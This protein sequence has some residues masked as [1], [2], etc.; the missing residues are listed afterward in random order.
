MSELLAARLRSELSAYS[1]E[2][3]L[4]SSR[5]AHATTSFVP[6]TE[7]FGYR[8]G[9]CAGNCGGVCGG[10][11][12]SRTGATYVSHVQSR[13][14]PTQAHSGLMPTSGGSYSYTAVRAIG[15]N[16]SCSSRMGP[17]PATPVIRAESRDA[18]LQAC[19]RAG[20]ENLAGD[21]TSSYAG[22][23]YNQLVGAAGS[24]GSCSS[25]MGPTPATPVIR[26]ES[27]AAPLQD[28]QRA[29]SENL[30][31]DNGPTP[32][33]PVIRAESRAAPFQASFAP[34]G[35]QAP[36]SLTARSLLRPLSS[37]F[38]SCSPGP[39]SRTLQDVFEYPQELQRER[40]LVATSEAR[41]HMAPAAQPQENL[42]LPIGS[43]SPQ[44]GPAVYAMSQTLE[45]SNAELPSPTRPSTSPSSFSS[46]AV[47]VS[48]ETPR[49]LPR[50]SDASP[51]GVKEVPAVVI[52]TVLTGRRLA[53][54]KGSKD[55]VLLHSDEDTVSTRSSDEGHGREIGS[56]WPALVTAR[57]VGAQAKASSPAGVESLG[58]SSKTSE[59]AMKG[60][61]R[62]A[63][64]AQ[65][66]AQALGPSAA[67]TSSA[68]VAATLPTGSPSDTSPKVSSVSSCSPTSQEPER[69]A[70]PAQ[71]PVAF[72]EG[73]VPIILRVVDHESGRPRHIVR[74]EDGTVRAFGETT[75]KSLID[76]SDLDAR[77]W[78]DGLTHRELRGLVHEVGRRLLWSSQLYHQHKDELGTMADSS[79]YSFFGLTPTSTERDLDNAYRRLAKQMHPDK[80]GG[81]EEAK[82]RFQNMKERYEGLKERRSTGE[83]QNKNPEMDDEESDA[84]EEEEEEVDRD[85][86]EDEDEDRLKKFRRRKGK[87]S[88]NGRIEFDPTDRSSLDK[89]VWKM[90]GQLRTLQR[91]L[92]DIVKMLARSKGRGA[93]SGNA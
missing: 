3:T 41:Q 65:R 55:T 48:R 17:T 11:S 18:F 42:T 45:P 25:R 21:G 16:G 78:L 12:G 49:I 4:P 20:S 56:A 13:P 79:D 14:A 71:E 44:S 19:Q 87:N 76:S 50:Q 92:E 75:V 31:G 52:R 90:L 33:T 15:G 34:T 83:G 62:P 88:N 77:K 59:E 47:P 6:A 39:Q 72:D 60:G 61:F 91:G 23:Y 22:G 57:G 58:P 30:V 82:K 63:A 1:L 28:R 29:A 64:S 74:N 67:G 85:V 32:A 35:Y 36:Q 84:D 40:V 43:R 27:R 81:T 2:G 38:V 5:R 86:P 89:T 68:Q 70:S 10:S 80:N 51:V 73:G 66:Y 69:E 7:V 53:A 9:S 8:G 54:E 26:A 46:W 24:N 37:A 93:K